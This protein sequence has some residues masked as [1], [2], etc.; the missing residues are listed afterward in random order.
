[1]GR[2]FHRTFG[3]ELF[4]SA[5]AESP[6]LWVIPGQSLRPQQKFT[7]LSAGRRGAEFPNHRGG[8]KGRKFWL[9][10]EGRSLR[11]QGRSLRPTPFP[12]IYG[13]GPIGGRVFLE[14]LGRN[15]FCSGPRAE[16]PA[17]SGG[18]SAPQKSFST[19]KG[20][21]FGPAQPAMVRILDAPI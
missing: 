10:Q 5:R 2:K 8:N 11:P 4:S 20:G 9:C 16:T 6:A 15:N 12:P 17:P 19:T 18:D 21:N 7:R 14:V 1:M 13:K 3:A